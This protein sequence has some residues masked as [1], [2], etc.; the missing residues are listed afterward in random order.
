MLPICIWPY[1]MGNI[2]IVKKLSIMVL[3]KAKVC[4]Y[5]HVHIL[6]VLHFQTKNLIFFIPLLL[7]SVVHYQKV[8]LLSRVRL[9]AIPWTVVYQASLSMGFSKQEY[10]SGVPFPT[11]GD[12][13]DPGIEPR[14]PELQADALP[15]EHQGSPHYQNY[16]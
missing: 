15:S 14:S 12:L 9:F 3:D 16:Q 4:V 5:V 1:I 6:K 7:F 10:W 13:P 11:P 2:L 8:K